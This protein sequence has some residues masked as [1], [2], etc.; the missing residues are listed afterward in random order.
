MW[1]NAIWVTTVKYKQSRLPHI[2]SSSRVKFVLTWQML[3]VGMREQ[4][5]QDFLNK[6]MEGSEVT[7]IEDILIGSPGNHE[8]GL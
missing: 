2:V 1:H 5:E 8:T 3:Y 4:E 7:P 6:L